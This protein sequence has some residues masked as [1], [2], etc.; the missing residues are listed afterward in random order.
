MKQTLLLPQTSATKYSIFTS[1]V[2]YN[3]SINNTQSVPITLVD[4]ELLPSLVR[5]R[6][7]CFIKKQPILY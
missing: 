3:A 2:L 5:A 4:I 7:S 6:I 1:H